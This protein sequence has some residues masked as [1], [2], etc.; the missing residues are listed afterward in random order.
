M[1]A[2]KNRELKKA[3]ERM[4]QRKLEEQ[5]QIVGLSDESSY[6][7]S[8]KEEENHI[9]LT[10]FQNKSM[11]L[12]SANARKRKMCKLTTYLLMTYISFHLYIAKNT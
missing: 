7:I 8:S 3:Q 2:K 12:N 11:V 5:K 1:I 4:K 9:M 10:R 6:A